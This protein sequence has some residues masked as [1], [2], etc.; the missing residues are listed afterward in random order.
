MDTQKLDRESLL[1]IV[2]DSAF[3]VE[4]RPL[5]KVEVLL[6]EAIMLLHNLGKNRLSRHASEDFMEYYDSI[7]WTLELERIK[8]IKSAKEKLT[9]EERRALGV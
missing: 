6:N 5:P 2:D 8:H 7:I 4:A 1:E 3:M 9:I